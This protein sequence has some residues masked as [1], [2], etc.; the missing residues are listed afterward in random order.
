MTKP[1][2]LSGEQV[3]LP[4]IQGT[5]INNRSIVD[6]LRPGTQIRDNLEHVGSFQR[7]E[8]VE[9]RPYIRI[10]FGRVDHIVPLSSIGKR[11]HLVS[12]T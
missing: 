11:Y 6:L 3:T 12:S 5:V 9:G 10:S 2:E 4:P 8:V 7:M 1:P